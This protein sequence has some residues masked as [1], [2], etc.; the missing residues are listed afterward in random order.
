MTHAHNR[1]IALDLRQLVRN[2]LEFRISGCEFFDFLN[3]E[4]RIFKTDISELLSSLDEAPAKP[5]SA[6]ACRR[7][8]PC[9]FFAIRKDSGVGFC[10]GVWFYLRL[11]E[12]MQVM[13]FWVFDRQGQACPL[14]LLGSW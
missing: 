11:G 6:P 12:G 2:R 14:E 9:R 3:S 5:A 8:T 1:F 13:P 7:Q 4:L 10:S